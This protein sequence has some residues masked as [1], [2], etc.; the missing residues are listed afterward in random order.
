MEN[1]DRELVFSYLLS[2]IRV[3]H[4]RLGG[5]IGTL[6]I[7]P[8][9]SDSR[10]AEVVMAF[11]KENRENMGWSYNDPNLTQVDTRKLKLR[12]TWK[13]RVSAPG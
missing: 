6:T 11:P 13:G 7:I 10:G 2:H 1:N 3:L 5:Q 8:I 4:L 9:V 12:V